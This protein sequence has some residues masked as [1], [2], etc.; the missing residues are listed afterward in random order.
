MFMKEDP[1]GGRELGV[2]ENWWF[3]FWLNDFVNSCKCCKNLDKKSWK[4]VKSNKVWDISIAKKKKNQF[5]HGT[6]TD[7]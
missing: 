2:H 1:G 4:K 5:L 7:F 3:W 6:N